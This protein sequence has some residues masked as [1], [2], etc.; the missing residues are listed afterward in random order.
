MEFQLDVVGAATDQHDKR[1]STA[2]PAV[3]MRVPSQRLFGPKDAATYLGVHEDTLKKM[4]ALEQ[5]P[6]YNLN[7][8]RAYRLEDLAAF[9]ESLPEWYDSAGEKSAKIVEKG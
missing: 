6:A 7:G 2:K 5:I 4:T 8:R 3:V 9:V 1:S